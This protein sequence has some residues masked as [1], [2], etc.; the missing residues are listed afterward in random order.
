MIKVI[1]NSWVCAATTSAYGK[2]IGSGHLK[3]AGDDELSGHLSTSRKV[4]LP[5]P[6]PPLR[7]YCHHSATVLLANEVLN[8]TAPCF[9]L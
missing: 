7:R 9:Q 1:Y 4:G 2:A 5:V 3:S 8:L 6:H